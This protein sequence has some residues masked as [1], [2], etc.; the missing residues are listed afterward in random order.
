MRNEVSH[1]I[2]CG[3]LFPSRCLPVLLSVALLCGV[4]LATAMD[5]GEGPSVAPGNSSPA[6]ILLP[7]LW[8]M[9]GQFTGVAQW[10]P[11]FVAPYS[12]VNSL[13]PGNRNEETIDLTFYAGM[14][15]W[16]GG[17]IWINPEI[18]QGFGLNNTLGVAGFPSGE[19]YKVGM[20]H[21]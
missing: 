12:G 8:R 6:T 15:V 9:H 5:A 10:H 20:D 3:R 2:R 14:R 7:E 11:Q 21:P 16:Q 17:E 4:R 1:A 18:D 13:S 19:A